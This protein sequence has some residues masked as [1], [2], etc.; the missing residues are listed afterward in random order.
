MA[1]D[2]EGEKGYMNLRQVYTEG[3]KEDYRSWIA[4]KHMKL[5]DQMTPNWEHHRNL[6]KD[7][8]DDW[9]GGKMLEPHK[10]V[11]DYCQILH[12]K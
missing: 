7:D 12:Y 2:E 8:W 11:L 10:S 9:S 3:K 1:V 5:M 6:I 4:G